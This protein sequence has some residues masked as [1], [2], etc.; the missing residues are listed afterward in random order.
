[1][2]GIDLDRTADAAIACALREDVDGLVTLIR[3]LD[4]AE[5]RRLVGRLAVRAAEGL[6]GWAADAGAD[7]E[8]AVSMWQDAILRLERAR[9]HDPGD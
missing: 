9:E 8:Q 2:H 5:L 1:M 7:H 3:P 4:A 6:E